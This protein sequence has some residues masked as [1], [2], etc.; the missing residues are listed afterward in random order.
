MSPQLHDSR[1]EYKRYLNC[2]YFFDSFAVKFLKDN[3]VGVVIVIT[4]LIWIPVCLLV[5]RYDR[6]KRKK[7]EGATTLQRKYNAQR[8]SAQRPSNSSER[9]TV[10]SNSA[11]LTPSQRPRNEFGNQLPRNPNH[12]RARIVRPSPRAMNGAGYQHTTSHN[13]NLRLRPLLDTG[14]DVTSDDEGGFTGVQRNCLRESNPCIIYP[15]SSVT[16]N[17]RRGVNSQPHVYAEAVRS[18]HVAYYDQDEI[19]DNPVVRLESGSSARSSD[20]S[21]QI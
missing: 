17:A 3:I 19:D 11:N 21:I 5:E 8:P 16:Y 4:A 12:S 15:N 6:G 10:T 20:R 9:S 14:R 2:F 7:I 13:Y 18:S 1:I